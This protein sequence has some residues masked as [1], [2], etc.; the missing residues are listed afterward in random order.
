MEK[1][2][3]ATGICLYNLCLLLFPLSDSRCQLFRICF[4]T[5]YFSSVFRY[6]LNTRRN[7]YVLCIDSQIKITFLY[8]IFVCIWEFGVSNFFPNA[9]DFGGCLN[10]ETPPLF[11]P[12]VHSIPNFEVLTLDKWTSRQALYFKAI[13]AALKD[14]VIWNSIANKPPLNITEDL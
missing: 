2:L 3:L 12:L 14:F 11:T 6:D 5:D 9:K 13:Q 4:K 7:I 10:T 1:R 8:H